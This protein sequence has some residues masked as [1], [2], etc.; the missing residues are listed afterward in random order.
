Y[1]HLRRKKLTSSPKFKNSKAMP[2]ASDPAA[3]KPSSPSH[4][5]LILS[6]SS[7][8][9]RPQ[10]LE[11]ILSSLPSSQPRDLQMLDRIALNF[12]NLPPNHYTEAI[13]AH[14]PTEEQFGDIDVDYHEL[15]LVF[16]KILS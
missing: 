2:T 6:P 12:A 14:T 9:S 5:I 15:K 8:S 3:F 10:I 4:P 11:S 1:S 16:N 7:L 13:L